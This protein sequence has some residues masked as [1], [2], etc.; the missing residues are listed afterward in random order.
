MVSL[1]LIWQTQDYGQLLKKNITADKNH[2]KV[3]FIP[4]SIK[5]WKMI[6][7][8]CWPQDNSKTGTA[9]VKHCFLCWV[10]EITICLIFSLYCWDFILF[11]IMLRFNCRQ[12]VLHG[13]TN[14]KPVKPM[15]S[16]CWNQRFGRHFYGLFNLQNVIKCPF[17]PWN[18]VLPQIFNYKCFGNDILKLNLKTKIVAI[19]SVPFFIGTVLLCTVESCY[20]SV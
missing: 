7:S 6:K 10:L 2:Q 15:S 1:Y 13:F 18:V 16:F 20:K 5:L 3:P 17:F 8:S 4:K 11:I 12:C 9:R 19:C 14:V